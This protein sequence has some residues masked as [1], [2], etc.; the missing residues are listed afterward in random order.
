MTV[1]HGDS[2]ASA[3]NATAMLIMFLVAAAV[4]I[5]LLFYFAPWANDSDNDGSGGGIDV[6]INEGSG[7]GGSGSNDSGSGSGNTNMH[8]PA[9]GFIITV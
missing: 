1:H 4:I 6:D 7:S 8:I 3:V 9:D 5:G 2:G